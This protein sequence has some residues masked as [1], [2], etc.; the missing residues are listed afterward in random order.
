[1][2][3]KKTYKQACEILGVT[4]MTLIKYVKEL[5][6][7]VERTSGR[8]YIS[9]ED[10]YYIMNYLCNKK[11]K[12]ENLTL[13]EMKKSHHLVKDDRCFDINYWPEQ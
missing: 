10:V 7:E 3:N 9:E 11:S 5:K 8:F 13:E 4:K 1:M 12:K 6:I 2:V